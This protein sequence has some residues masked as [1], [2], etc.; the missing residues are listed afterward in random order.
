[1]LDARFGEVLSVKGAVCVGYVQTVSF[2]ESRIG[3]LLGDVMVRGANPLVATLPGDSVVKVRI[4]AWGDGS[5]EG[6]EGGSAGAK[7]AAMEELIAGRLGRYVF[8]R[9][10]V[11]RTLGEVVQEL[12]IKEGKTVAVAESCTAGLLGKMLT[13]R[14]GSSEFFV[15]GWEVYTNAMKVKC[16]GADEDLIAR[17]G[18][19]SAECAEAMARGAIERAGSD[20]SISITGIAGPGGGT[21]EKPVGTVFVGL[22]M[23]K[24][25]E[26]A[27]GEIRVV[28]KRFGFSG[29]RDQVRQRAAMAGMAMLC[30]DLMSAG[31]D[32][33]GEEGH[34]GL[35]AMLWEVGS[36]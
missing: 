22:A 26:V 11:E 13:E 20:Y 1:M 19:V 24:E 7:A 14:A 6:G 28:V 32:V 21:D 29:A 16:L 18:A 5:E 8:S 31:D 3:E 4:R 30:F 36:R 27:D 33:E 34:R 9:G 15:G 10:K 12:M 23:R 25:G 2:A 17:Y 35:P